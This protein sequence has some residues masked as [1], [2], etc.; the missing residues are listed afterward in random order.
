MPERVKEE[1]GLTDGDE[2][3]EA[4]EDTEQVGL[5]DF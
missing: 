3:T 2:E 4:D 1:H 5:T